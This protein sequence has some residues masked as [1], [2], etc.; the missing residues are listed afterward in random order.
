MFVEL[1]Q[2]DMIIDLEAIF[3]LHKGTTESGPYFRLSYAKDSY[4]D[5][6][7][8][9]ENDYWNLKA[10]LLEHRQTSQQNGKMK[11]ISQTDC[12]HEQ[13]KTVCAECGKD[14]ENKQKEKK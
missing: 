1:E 10:L 13:S 2:D 4:H 12:K 7:A 11:H 5:S 14:L 8:I 9:T 6:I 3:R